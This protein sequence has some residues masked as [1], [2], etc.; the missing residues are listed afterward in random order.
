MGVN[1][2]DPPPR[3]NVLPDHA[4]HEVRL[5]R[6]G[7][8]DDIEVPPAVVLAEVRVPRLTAKDARAETQPGAEHTHGRGRFARLDRAE[9]RRFERDVRE[10]PDTR[11]FF[12]REDECGFRVEQAEGK[13]EERTRALAAG[14][15]PDH[16]FVEARVRVLQER[17][18]DIVDD[19]RSAFLGRG[20]PDNADVRFK[21]GLCSLGLDEAHL[22]LFLRA[23]AVLR[24][25]LV[26]TFPG[27]LA[28]CLRRRKPSFNRI[29]RAQ[30]RLPEVYLFCVARDFSR[31][32]ARGRARHD[33]ERRP[34]PGVRDP[35][36]GV[37]KLAQGVGFQAPICLEGEDG[38]A[39]ER[40]RRRRGSARW[41]E[42]VIVL[43][44]LDVR[45]GKGALD[46]FFCHLRE[47]PRHGDVHGD[48][49]ADMGHG[50]LEGKSGL[51]GDGGFPPW[52]A[53]RAKSRVHLFHD[54][55]AIAEFLEGYAFLA[56][57]ARE[58]YG[59]E[60]EVERA[61]HGIARL[62]AVEKKRRDPEEDEHG[63]ERKVADEKRAHGV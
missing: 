3:A 2:T 59:Q 40:Q 19:C 33:L 52:F 25:G 39:L 56:R 47:A 20:G 16:K 48:F 9:L 10:V 30:G 6:A 24:F 26:R 15:G 8:S 41:I 37:G 44:G 49:L 4:H 61:P 29:P 63:D 21:Q 51:P 1:E 50:D 60:P 27:F 46:H 12:A 13:T 35:G 58:R 36:E 57:D 14:E 54:A 62:A 45:V 22:L 34:L 28:C 7:L 43:H 31:P 11:Q 42:D 23:Q 32:L 5:A 53:D 17:G 55:N 38:R 18:A